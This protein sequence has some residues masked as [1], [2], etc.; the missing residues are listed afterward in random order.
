[1]QL[2]RTNVVIRARSLSEIGDLALILIRCYPGAAIFGFALGALPWAI[3]N[4][5]LIGWIPLPH[6][7]EG[8]HDE[9]MD[10]ALNRYVFLM[11]S[12]VI[13]QAPIAGVLTTNLI[14]RTVFEQQVTWSSALA[15]LRGTFRRWFWV[16]GVLRGPIPLMLILAS[17]WGQEFA[18]GREV[19]IPILCLIIVAFQR[20]RRPFLPEILLLERCPL[21]SRSPEVI[22]A[23]R[24]SACAAWSAG[25]GTDRT[26]YRSFADDRRAVLSSP[27]FARLGPRRDARLVG[28]VTGRVLAVCPVIAV[29]GGGSERT[30]SVSQ[31]S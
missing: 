12:L 19:F 28:L 30:D 14:G 8:I 5:L 29:G 10:A 23:R 13:L 3:L 18:V 11:I 25:R 4:L 16:L 9:Q 27:L 17:N 15:D 6:F 2:D 21:R 20:G 24:R 31:L 7:S 1:M 26:F 22:S